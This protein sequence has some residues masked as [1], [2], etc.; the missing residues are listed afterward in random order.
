M[1]AHYNAYRKTLNHTGASR[2]RDA[3]E[4]ARVTVALRHAET[5][6]DRAQAIEETRQIWTRCGV[7]ACHDETA[8]PD[9]IRRSMRD[10]ASDMILAC[11]KAAAGDVGSLRALIEVNQS[12]VSGLNPAMPRSFHGDAFHPRVRQVA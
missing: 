7:N 1:H 3:S 5:G 2:H 8:M 4:L 12:V 9:E 11:A 10:L 6:H